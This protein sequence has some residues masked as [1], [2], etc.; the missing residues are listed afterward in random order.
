MRT[1]DRRYCTVVAELNW[2]YTGVITPAVPVPVCMKDKVLYIRS[3]TVLRV[4]VL[5]LL[6][7]VTSVITYFWREKMFSTD[8]DTSTVPYNNIITYSTHRI[9]IQF[10][11]WSSETTSID[12]VPL[13]LLPVDSQSEKPYYYGHRNSRMNQSPRRYILN[14]CFEREFKEGERKRSRTNQKKLALT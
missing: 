11:F 7:R 3:G 13:Q 4:H 10:V 12:H 1:R 5:R 8:V 14:Y 6:C 2:R 9:K